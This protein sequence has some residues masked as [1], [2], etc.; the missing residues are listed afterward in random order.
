MR[1]FTEWRRGLSRQ[2][3]TRVLAARNRWERQGMRTVVRT[4]YSMTK[5]FT[6]LCVMVAAALSSPAS[7]HAQTAPATPACTAPAEVTR[8][9]HTLTH[10]ARRLARRA[11]YDRGVRLVLHR[12]RWGKLAGRD[13]PEPARSRP[14]DALSGPDHQR[15][16]PRRRRRGCERDAGPHGPGRRAGTAGSG[17]LAGRH[18]RGAEQS[19]ARGRGA[20]DPRGNSPYEGARGRYRVN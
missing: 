13:L 9:G 4:S 15:S 18:Q 2:V 11:H 3:F 8:L 19:C 5:W 7:L 16:E 6:G 17:A 1:C 10:M 12:R 20:P 14:Q